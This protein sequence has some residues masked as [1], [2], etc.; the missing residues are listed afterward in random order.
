MTLCFSTRTYY[1]VDVVPICFQFLQHWI[2]IVIVF[3]LVVT[4]YNM[5]FALLPIVDIPVYET[6]VRIKS[7][8][9]KLL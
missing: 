3:L 2:R 8:K 1:V 5:A 4:R 6:D 9:Y 7:D